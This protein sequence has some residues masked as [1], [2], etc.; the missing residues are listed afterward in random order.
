MIKCKIY[1]KKKLVFGE[2]NIEEPLKVNGEETQN[3]EE[4]IYLG[5]TV[6]YDIDSKR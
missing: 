2:R 6:S 5:S 3:V 4:F 1:Q